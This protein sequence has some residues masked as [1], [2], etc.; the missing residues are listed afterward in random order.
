VTQSI[1]LMMM[2]ITSAIIIKVMPGVRS[3][4]LEPVLEV[5]PLLQH[6]VKR[7]PN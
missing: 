4:L 3:A 1:S 5:E 7:N 6:C 2:Q